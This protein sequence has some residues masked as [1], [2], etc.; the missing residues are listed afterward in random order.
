MKLAEIKIGTK[1]A[2]SREAIIDACHRVHFSQEHIANVAQSAINE[3]R[4]VADRQFY[5]SSPNLSRDIHEASSQLMAAH[6]ALY[7]ALDPQRVLYESIIG[8]TENRFMPVKVLEM[9]QPYKQRFDGVRVE[10]IKLDSG[11][12]VNLFLHFSALWCEWDNRERGIHA[13]RAERTIRQ[14]S[15]VDDELRDIL[16]NEGGQ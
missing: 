11:E 10:A 16:G 1:Y 12:P 2:V 4:L 15:H 8:P 13:I 7:D 9:R 3:A 14:E 5:A 6:S